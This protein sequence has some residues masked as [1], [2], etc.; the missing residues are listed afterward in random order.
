M[1]GRGSILQRSKPPFQL[2]LHLAMTLPEEGVYALL[3]AMVN[4]LRFPCSHTHFFA[5]I[6]LALFEEC[7]PEKPVR[8]ILTRVLLERVIVMRP[9]PWGVVVTFLELMR[10]EKYNFMNHK[11]VSADP[12]FEKIFQV[13]LAR[14]AGAGAVGLPN[15]PAAP[16]V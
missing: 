12:A 11:F 16:V 2:L 13:F 15:T 14:S 4:Q 7:P 8:E 10:N 3:F 9:Y 6:C 5:S 1:E